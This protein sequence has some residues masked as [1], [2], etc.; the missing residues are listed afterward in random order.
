MHFA[1]DNSGP[2]H[3]EVMAALQ[4]ANAGYALPYG[5]DGWTKAAITKVRRVFEAP[6]AAVY[7]TA[8]GSAANALALATITDPYQTVFC[9]AD[10]HIEQDECNAPEFYSGGAKLTLVDAVDAK[11]DPGALSRMLESKA[12]SNVHGAQIGPVSLTQV[13]ERGTV[14]TLDELRALADIAKR[15]E[16]KL[17][18]D[19][20]RFANA[21]VALDCTAPEMSWQA[22]VDIV[23]FGGTKNGLMAVEAVVIFDP[24]LAW[25]FELRRKRGGHLFS[26]ARYLAAQMEAYLTDDLWLTMARDANTAGQRLARSLDSIDGVTLLHPPEAN[27]VFA[28]LPKAAHRRLQDAGAQYYPEAGAD[29]GDGVASARMVA[30]WSCS[31]ASVTAFLDLVRG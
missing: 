22:G 17:H 6:E 13:T 19:G 9:T 1:S 31:A 5:N 29:K 30:D 12:G 2:V 16:T 18:L 26:K 14:Y 24:A 11:M 3:P 21:M 7:F 4:E 8:T 20:A 25:Q 10:A 15:H 23:S 28:S 27:M